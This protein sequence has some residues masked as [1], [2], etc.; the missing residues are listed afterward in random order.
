MKLMP[1]QP[2]PALAVET[3]TGT[4]FDIAQQSPK[5]FTQIVF[6]RG[7]HCPICKTYLKSIDSRLG[8]FEEHGINTIAISMDGRDRAEEVAKAGELRRLAI[9]YGL[10][11]ATARS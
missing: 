5:N 7:L 11:E 2:V 1:D 9:G 8:E 3:L 6:Y 4:R 10:S